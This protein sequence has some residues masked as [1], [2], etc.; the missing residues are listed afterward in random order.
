MSSPFLFPIYPRIIYIW[1]WYWGNVVLILFWRSATAIDF[2][3][4]NNAIILF[5][6][7]IS[8]RMWKVAWIKA[9]DKGILAM[10]DRVL[11]NN[12]RLSVLH[13]DLHTWTLHIRDVHRSDRGVYM[14]QINSDPMLSQVNIWLF[15]NPFC[16]IFEILFCPSCFDVIFVSLSKGKIITWRN[17]V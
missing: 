17:E 1:W 5:Q 10:H 4:K 3:T 7:L 9:D 12:A 16:P 8:F 14:C 15:L 2:E 6:N 11:T 13:S